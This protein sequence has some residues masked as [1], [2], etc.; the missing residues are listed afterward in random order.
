MAAR[1]ATMKDVATLANVSKSAVS[2]AF[3]DPKKLSEATCKNIL[4]AAEELGYTQD[5]T[6]RM[7]RTH[8]TDSLGLL[9]PQQLDKVLENP[10]YTQF[11]QG[12]GQTCQREGF[13]LLLAPPLRG[14][15]LKAIPYAAVDGF[16]VSGLEYDRGEVKALRQRGIPFVLVDSEWHQ[17]V[18]SVEVDDSQGIRELVEYLLA[19]G[20]RR[21]AFVAIET[22][23][24]GG[25]RHWKGPVQRR[26]QGAIDGLATADLGPESEGIGIIEVP[27][28]RAG[29][30]TAFRALW[31]QKE[32]PTA[33]VAFSDIIAFG[34]LDAAREAGVE[35]PTQLSVSGFDDLTE[36]SWT[37]PTL[38]TIRQPIATKGRLAAEYLVEAIAGDATVSTHQQRL[39]TTLLLRESTGPAPRQG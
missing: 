4:R 21:I 7:L 23:T 15:M 36:A 35:V 17:D 38:T 10:Y 2:L 30:V 8:R 1:R 16:I 26:M 11:L 34:I 3:N 19:Q 25:Y 28:T 12:I 32:P 18:P 37:T 24:A 33:M 9:L 22:D 5:P 27:C 6:A 14:S 31:D 13:T 20:H 39:A 29:G